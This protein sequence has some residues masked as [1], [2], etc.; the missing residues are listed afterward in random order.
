MINA[1]DEAADSSYRKAGE[2]ATYI[3]EISKQAVM[4]K[5]H[6]IEIV[7]PEIKVDKKRELKI[8]YVEADEDHVALQEKS[9]SG[10]MRR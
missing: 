7:E 8:L 3:D 10:R 9:I 6:N 4:N 1:I 5:V 2:K